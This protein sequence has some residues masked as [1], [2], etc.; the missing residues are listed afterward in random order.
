M[1]KKI[2]IVLGSL[3]MV[4]TGVA[5]VSAF[6]AYVVNVTAHIENALEIHG[7][8][9]YDFGTVFPQ[10]KFEKGFFEVRTST[11]FCEDKQT[12]VMNI[13]YKI[14]QKPKPIWPKPTACTQ[15]YT[16]IEQARAY[17]IANPTDLTCCYPLLCP[18]LSK[19]PKHAETGDVGIPAYHLPGAVATGQ[20][21]KWDDLGDEWVVDLDVPCFKGECAQDWTH[22][23]FEPDPSL[24]GATFGCDLWV[25]VTRI[26]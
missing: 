2:L 14:A 7:L 23:S 25:E 5:A 10:E 26:Y 21:K 11:S 13:D 4:I 19:N 24:D 3:V 9:H 1:R 8:T 15:L 12:R 17:C 22:P 18:Y 20:L 16:T 6:E